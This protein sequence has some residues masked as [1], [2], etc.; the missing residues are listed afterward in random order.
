MAEIP[1]LTLDPTTLRA[2][3]N[4][5]PSGYINATS[6]ASLI[7]T[8]IGSTAPASHT[9]PVSQIATVGGVA[10]AGTFLRGDGEWAAIDVSAILAEIANT[11]ML[12]FP[13]AGAFPAR[14]AT[15]RHIFYL[16][17]TVTPTL[18]G[19]LTGGGGMVPN[20]DVLISALP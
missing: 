17:S 6:V 20:Y 18:D 7:S 13:V 10:S 4:R 19:S 14:P 8:A 1:V 15:N 9:H 16:S 5:M 11:P 12:L 2:P 3:E